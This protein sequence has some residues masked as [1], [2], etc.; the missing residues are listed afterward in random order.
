[1]QENCGICHRISSKELYD[2]IKQVCNEVG[3]SEDKRKILFNKS[4]KLLHIG[5]KK[6]SGSIWCGRTKKVI[7]AGII[8]SVS[9]FYNIIEYELVCRSDTPYLKAIKITQVAIFDILKV[10]PA[11]TRQMFKKIIEN[12]EELKERKL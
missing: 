10:H 3:I 12:V 9:V 2:Y 7:I 5:D 1:M 4:I 6:E 11:S 8:Y